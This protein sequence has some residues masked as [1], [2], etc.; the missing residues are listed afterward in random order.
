M[1]FYDTSAPLI[2]TG[3]VTTPDFSN[4][5]F[6]Y[7]AVSGSNVLLNIVTG[8]A[9]APFAFADTDVITAEGFYEA[10]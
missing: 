9:S 3:Y 10:A 7:F 6:R 1:S 8:G 5:T 4:L 2:I